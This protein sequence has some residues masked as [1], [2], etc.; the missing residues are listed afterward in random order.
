MEQGESFF[1]LQLVGS[2]HPAF[3]HA[4]IDDHN[5]EQDS[6]PPQTQV[7]PTHHQPPSL[8]Q[9]GS[10]P[11]ASA[12]SYLYNGG[13]PIHCAIKGLAIPLSQDN[14]II[15]PDADLVAKTNLLQYGQTLN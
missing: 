14:F 3:L 12:I 10:A 11:C 15:M 13:L 6:S 2:A 4:T 7:I 9:P 1:L 5:E 8:A